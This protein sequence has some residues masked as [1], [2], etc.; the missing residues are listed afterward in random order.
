M[1][2]LQQYENISYLI[3]QMIKDYRAKILSSLYEKIFSD[4]ILYSTN[5]CKDYKVDVEKISKISDVI[6]LIGLKVSKVFF[7]MLVLF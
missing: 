6:N 5:R 7:W 3:K 4:N 1:F 2:R